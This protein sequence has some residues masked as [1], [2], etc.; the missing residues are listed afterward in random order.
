MR[1]YQAV[2]DARNADE[3]T[4]EAASA[5]ATAV[6][7]DIVGLSE[8]VAACLNELKSFVNPYL[9]G[10]LRAAAVLAHAAARAAG[11]TVR[12]NLPTMQDREQATRLER[13]VEALVHEAARHC[14]AV[15]GYRVE[16]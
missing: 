15:V 8:S 14:E 1:A 6:P 12:D 9:I 11:C 4:R 3:A 7:M 2:R 16:A 5:K 10:D 13:Q